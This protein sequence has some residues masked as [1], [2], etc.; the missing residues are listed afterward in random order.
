MQEQESSQK[1]LLYI[2]KTRFKK[3]SKTAIHSDF[4]FSFFFSVEHFFY[5]H[6]EFFFFSKMIFFLSQQKILCL[7]LLM[8]KHSPFVLFLFYIKE[9][10]FY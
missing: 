6:K 8:G 1:Y 7:H 9:K 4:G 3:K 5:T 10:K 2:T